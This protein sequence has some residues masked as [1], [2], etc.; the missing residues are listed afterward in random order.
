RGAGA[1]SNAEV[2][3]LK[4]HIEDL[5]AYIERLKA[6]AGH[7]EGENELLRRRNAELEAVTGLGNVGWNQ[8]RLLSHAIKTAQEAIKNKDGSNERRRVQGD[9][10]AYIIDLVGS[11]KIDDLD[12]ERFDLVYRPKPEE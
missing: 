3:R 10:G 7:S 6:Q 12:V 1:N 2:E 9:V 4:A 8:R 5:E 11:A